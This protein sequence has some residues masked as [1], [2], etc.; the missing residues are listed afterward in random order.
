[1]TRIY[2][3]EQQQAT[4][5]KESLPNITRL[6]PRSLKISKVLK[7]YSYPAILLHPYT[8][9]V[10]DSIFLTDLLVTTESPMFCHIAATVIF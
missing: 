9:L 4:S 7:Y 8:I 10:Q 6:M 5:N 2:D 3:R 1:M